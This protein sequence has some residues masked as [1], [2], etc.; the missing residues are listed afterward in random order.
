MGAQYKLKIFYDVVKGSDGKDYW[1]ITR[2]DSTLL[3]DK[4]KFEFENLFNGNK[5]LCTYEMMV[6]KKTEKFNIDDRPFFL[7]HIF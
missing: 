5:L 7:K 3:P 2:H 6:Q 4:M 1:K